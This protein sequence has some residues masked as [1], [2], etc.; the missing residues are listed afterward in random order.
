MT[1]DAHTRTRDY[2]GGAVSDRR[3]T[4]V[5]GDAVASPGGQAALL[6]AANALV[7]NHPV[8]YVVTPDGPSAL[9][10]AGQLS[11]LLEGIGQATDESRLEIVRSPPSETIKIGLG[12]DVHADVYLGADRFTGYIADTPSPVSEAPTTIYGGATA[13]ML[14]AGH[15]FRRTIAMPVGELRGMSMWTLEETIAGSGPATV[16]P[17]NLGGLWLIGAGGVGS[18]AAWWIQLFGHRGTGVVIDHDLVDITNL[19]RSLGM[20]YA[21]TGLA[22]GEPKSKA[23]LAADLIGAKAFGE[24]WEQWIAA[25][26]DPPDLLIPAAN[27]YGVRSAIATYSHPM[28]FS[29]TTSRNWTAELHM[30]RAGIDSCPSCRHPEVVTGQSFA[31]S[32]SPIPSADGGSE[33]AA[34]S[35]LSGTAG[36]LSVAAL[37]L[38]QLNLT[39]EAA[40]MWA[41]DFGPAY[42]GLVR[43]LRMACNATCHRTLSRQLRSS[44]FG[45]TRHFK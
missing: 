37:N 29:G 7:R 6:G 30:Y 20:F 31:C 22:E 32:T 33:D 9:A 8:V 14:A 5:A 15:V 17:L 45:R 18:S 19:N 11:D 34:L 25:D 44:L 16:D 1:A 26:P 27:E 10:L 39:P 41:V 13:A 38:A 3:V 42:R 24:T 21:T 40:S 12:P 2:T 35:F 4:I 43:P 28:A 23:R 36:L